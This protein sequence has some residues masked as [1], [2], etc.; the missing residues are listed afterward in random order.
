[1]LIVIT[2]T[3]LVF[4]WSS[5][6]VS[7]RYWE[8]RTSIMFLKI[9]NIHQGRLYQTHPDLDPS[10][11][12]HLFQTSERRPRGHWTLWGQSENSSF[13][14]DSDFSIAAEDYEKCCAGWPHSGK[15]VSHVT[16]ASLTSRLCESCS[17][18][19]RHHPTPLRLH[20]EQVAIH[21]EGRHVVKTPQTEN[22]ANRTVLST[23][24]SDKITTNLHSILVYTWLNNW[25]PTLNTHFIVASLPILYQT[26]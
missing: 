15:S 8:P 9:V 14:P 6:S 17:W 1:M 24:N 2:T 11:D 21:S 19:R 12:H 26:T 3:Q 16:V 7:P 4:S 13:L 20:W 22:K 23:M 25:M 5:G 10:P 18:F